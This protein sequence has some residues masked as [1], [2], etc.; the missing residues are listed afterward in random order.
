MGT[1][2]KTDE[3]N[4]KSLGVSIEAGSDSGMNPDRGNIMFMLICNTCF[5]QKIKTWFFILIF[6]QHTITAQRLSTASDNSVA[7]KAVKKKSYRRR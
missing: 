6:Y 7:S 2:M 1:N 4:K 5:I 3:P